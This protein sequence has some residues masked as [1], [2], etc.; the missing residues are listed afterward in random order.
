MI[1]DFRSDISTLRSLL[2]D[3]ILEM[4]EKGV[5]QGNY[6]DLDQLLNFHTIYMFVIEAAYY[7]EHA[8]DLLED[9]Y[10]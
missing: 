1:K 9:F 4:A 6:R 7:L 10:E 2:Q 8:S 5:N 3:T